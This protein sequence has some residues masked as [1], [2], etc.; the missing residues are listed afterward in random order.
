[1]LSRR[2]WTFETP[3]TAQ[4][5]AKAPPGAPPTPIAAIASSPERSTTPPAS[6]MMLLAVANAGPVGVL[7]MRSANALVVPTPKIGPRVAIV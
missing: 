7:L 1:M 6:R 4:A 2:S 3:A 5:S